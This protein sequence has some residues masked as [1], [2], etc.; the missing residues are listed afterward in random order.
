MQSPPTISVT[1]VAW[2]L[3]TSCTFLESQEDSNVPKALQ[4]ADDIV[5][6]KTSTRETLELTTKEIRKLEKKIKRDTDQLEPEVRKIRNRIQALQQITAAR[7]TSKPQNA[8]P[9][10]TSTRRSVLLMGTCAQSQK[11][12]G[13]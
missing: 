5:I 1:K 10:R 3:R 6:K 8:K 4:F 12:K 2:G 13:L 7:T 11:L 9:C